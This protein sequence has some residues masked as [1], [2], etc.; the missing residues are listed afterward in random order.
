MQSHRFSHQ[1]IGRGLCC[2]GLVASVG[3]NLRETQ[4]DRT[5]RNDH[6]GRFGSIKLTCLNNDS[7]NCLKMTHSA[8]EHSVS[9]AITT[10]ELG[11]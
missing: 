5:D 6:L 9:V 11:I 8:F 3:M 4:D 1:L 10:D 7:M 2:R